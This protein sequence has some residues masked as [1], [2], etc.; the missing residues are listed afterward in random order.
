MCTAFIHK[1]NDVIFGFNMDLHQGAM[2]Y[3]V[4]AT[5]DWFG[6]GCK[7]DMALLPPQLPPFYQVEDGV[8]KIHGV[9]RRGVFANC[10]NN[11]NSRSA[12][13]RPT[14]DACSIDQVADDLLSGRRTLEDAR[15]FAEQVELVT[16]PQGRVDVPHPGFHALCGDS[17]GNILLLE[18]GNG[19]AVLRGNHAVL[20]NFP[21]LELPPDLNDR[22]A[23]FYGKDRYDTALTM[24]RAA[25]SCLTAEGGL[26]V[27]RATRQT[28]CWATRVSFV[29]S[30]REKTVYYCLEGDFDHIHTHR[31]S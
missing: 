14:P 30:C 19:Y 25:G 18:P 2:D 17:D 22:T 4:Y 24:L 31:F 29:C 16:V 26:A 13:F 1:G 11:M 3:Q 6:V 23:G 8:R 21:L 28:G 5:E 20:T 10:L 15:R 27:L 7:A 9:S 12:P